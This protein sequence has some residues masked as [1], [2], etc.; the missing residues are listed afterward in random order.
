MVFIKQHDFNMWKN[1]ITF[2]SWSF[3]PVLTYGCRQFDH[4]N[5]VS[6]T[7]PFGLKSDLFM[8]G[9]ISGKPLVKTS[10]IWRGKRAS[11]PPS[12]YPMMQKQ[13]GYDN[14][15]PA[16]Q[17]LSNQNAF[18][19]QTIKT[20]QKNNRLLHQSP[21]NHFVFAACPS[22]GTTRQQPLSSHQMIHQPK[23]LF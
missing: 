9:C 23:H 5:F 13:I 17:S 20:L 8:L 16:K 18:M 4:L 11:K 3:S 22:K 19:F 14:V 1:L 21:T 7:T 10:V 6:W 2:V 12:I 15:Q